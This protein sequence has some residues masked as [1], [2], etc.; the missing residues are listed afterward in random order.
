MP[1][2]FSIAMKGSDDGEAAG[3]RYILVKFDIKCILVGI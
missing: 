1:Q 2:N 3:N